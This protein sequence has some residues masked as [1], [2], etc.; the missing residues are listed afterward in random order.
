M[1]PP[2]PLW[3][4]HWGYTLQIY[5]KCSRYLEQIPSLPIQNCGILRQ[6][7]R[8]RRRRARGLSLMELLGLE[9]TELS[10]DHDLKQNV[11]SLLNQLISY[12][13]TS[14]Q[15]ALWPIFLQVCRRSGLN[16][17]ELSNLTQQNQCRCTNRTAKR[18]PCSLR[19]HGCCSSQR[20]SLEYR[21]I[22]AAHR[23]R[24]HLWPRNL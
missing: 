23:R 15:S 20:T 16:R 1:E 9:D 3:H 14:D 18:R 2:A 6:G 4:D 21:P 19:T 13:T 11:V 12:N 22:Q 8:G 10:M 5:F 7:R 17:K 24:T